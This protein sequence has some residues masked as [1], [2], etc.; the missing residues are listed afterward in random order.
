MFFGGSRLHLVVVA[1]EQ[2]FGRISDCALT[3]AA[4]DVVV[5]WK[6]FCVEI[7]FLRKKICE[8]SIV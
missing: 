1:R 7:K 8:G 5:G 6:I 3:V 2:V 4:R